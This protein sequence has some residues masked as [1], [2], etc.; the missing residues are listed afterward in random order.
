MVWK[1]GESG[2]PAGRKPG[3]TPAEK[4]IAALNK[5]GKKR[6]QKWLDRVAEMAWDDGRV[7]VAV[8]K[9]IIADKQHI[10]AEMKGDLIVN[11]V[12][13]AKKDGDNTT[14]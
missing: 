11:L 12:K 13:F 10:D 8:L 2:N 1:K 7:M 5:F 3:K 9:K 6:G 4:L 14:E